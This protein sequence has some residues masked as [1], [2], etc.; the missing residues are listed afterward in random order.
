MLEDTVL[1]EV[2]QGPYA[3]LVE[4]ERFEAPRDR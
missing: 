1:F 4:K 3:G 2:K